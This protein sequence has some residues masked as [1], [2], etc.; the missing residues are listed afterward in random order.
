MSF[1]S[2]DK[3]G[4]KNQT[5]AEINMVPLID[6]M[7]VLL[8]IF[9]ITAPLLTHSIS[10]QLPQATAQPTQTEQKSLDLAITAEGAL[11]LD[12]EEV[13]LAGL[14]AVLVPFAQQDPQPEIRIRADHNTRYELL[15]QVM[16]QAKASGLTRLGFVTLPQEPAE[17]MNN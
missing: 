9:L 16:S 7:L 11:F 14:T 6:V 15:A 10:V 4:T 3:S 2:F 8:V 5:N 12:D 1:G 17:S 13:D